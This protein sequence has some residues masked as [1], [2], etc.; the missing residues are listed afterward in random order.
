M[1]P[2]GVRT[3]LSPARAGSDHLTPVNTS[4]NNRLVERAGLSE[5]A[6]SKDPQNELPRSSCLL[7]RL[8]PA[9]SE[10][11]PIRT[12]C[13][14]RTFDVATFYRGPVENADGGGT[15]GVALDEK[16]R[17]GISGS[18]YGVITPITTSKITMR[19]PLLPLGVQKPPDTLRPRKYSALF[20]FRFSPL[21]RAE[22]VCS[23]ADRAAADL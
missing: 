8:F 17:Q 11:P 2:E 22:S 1:L 14:S 13:G 9:V 7:L 23:S 4:Q 6:A 18:S 19:H 12:P 10:A 5:E 16:L 15:V 3:F 21:R 20:C